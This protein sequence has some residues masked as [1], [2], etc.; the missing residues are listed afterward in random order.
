MDIIVNACYYNIFFLLL[1]FRLLDGHSTLIIGQD[2]QCEKE[3]EEVKV[4][5]ISDNPCFTC[6]CQKGVVVCEQ[7]ICP[8]AKGCYFLAFGESRSCCDVCLSCYH[9][10]V[11]HNSGSE[12]INSK[13]SCLTYSCQSG[14]I[15]ES[16]IH[17]QT[18]C[19][20]PIPPE[21]N[22]CC[23]RCQGCQING[24]NYTDGQTVPSDSSDPCLTCSCQKGN[25]VCKKKACPVLPCP[26]TKF[27]HKPNSCCP[28]CRGARKISD[29]KDKCLIGLDIHKNGD[30]FVY[31]QCTQCSCNMSTTFCKRQVCPPLECP[32]S[33]QIKEP[34]QCCPYCQRP[35]E[36]KTVCRSGGQIYQNGQHWQNGCSNCYCL[37]GKVRCSVEFCKTSNKCPAGQKLVHLPKKCCPVCVEDDGVC[38][39]FGDPHYRTFDGRTFN[40]QGTCKYTLINDC[41]HKRFTVQ[42]ANEARYS[43]MFSWTKSIILKIDDTKLVLGQYRNIKIG[44]KRVRLP[45]I[46]LG[47]LSVVE[48]NYT[49]TVRT[50]LGIRLNWDG[51]S[52][53]EV[54]VPSH[55][56]S[57]LCGLC[58]NYNDNPEDDFTT[59]KGKLVSSPEVFGNSWAVGRGKKCLISKS[60]QTTHAACES[61]L[62]TKVKAIYECNVLKSDLFR[63]CHSTVNAMPY[64][65]SCVMDMC[66]CPV[67]RKCH[68]ESLFAYAQHCKRLGIQ[69]NWRKDSGCEGSHCPKGSVYR[70][71]VYPC[72]KTCKN[73]QRAKPCRRKCRP[74][75]E[76]AEGTVWYRNKCIPTQL[77]PV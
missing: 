40:F 39:V 47:T 22:E 30:S 42:V 13:N 72:R 57:Q 32:P 49:V 2:V 73:Y 62:N 18:S 77:C 31:D 25:V 7:Q 21:P 44:K 56:K 41:A 1:F 64:Y 35:E 51:N 61:N 6:K 46:K 66:E 26:Q 38:T 8:Y 15:T 48:Q 34:E 71:C 14:I 50:N 55:F 43:K 67:G 23:P 16:T 52:Y 20:H 24:I 29:F 58:G 5:S 12:W 10:G 33:Y 3:G 76:C 69:L 36:R 68:C 11:S 28:E 27:V 4:K 63:P 54:F 65:R 53:L 70:S 17:C 75:C 37:Q 59:K 19:R 74:G 45:Y 9:E 60:L